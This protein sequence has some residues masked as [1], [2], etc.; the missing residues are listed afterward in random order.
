M[1]IRKVGFAAER[2]CLGKFGVTLRG[3]AHN[4]VGANMHIGANRPHLLDA[5]HEVVGGVTPSH[6]A[7]NEL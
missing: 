2:E 6:R 1:N 7:Q 4:H 5:P 3:K